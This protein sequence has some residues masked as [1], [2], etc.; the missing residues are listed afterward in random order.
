MAIGMTPLVPLYRVM[1]DPNARYDR[2]GIDNNQLFGKPLVAFGGLSIMPAAA[3]QVSSSAEAAPKAA[4][5]S[6]APTPL[7]DGVQRAGTLGTDTP[8]TLGSLVDV[9]A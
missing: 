3:T 9:R 8:S 7:A 5:V 6:Q 2:F 4:A 1:P